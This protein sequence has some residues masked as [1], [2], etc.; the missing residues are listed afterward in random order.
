MTSDLSTELLQE[1][2]SHVTFQRLEDIRISYFESIDSTQTYMS[3]VAKSVR[4]GDVAI[5]RVQTAGKGREGRTWESDSGGLW[6]TVVLR[7]PSSKVLE[8]LVL[9]S[10]GAVVKTLEEFGL[11]ACYIKPPND[12][13]CDGKKI[14]GVLADAIQKSVGDST[15]VYLGVGI[16]VNNETFQNSVIRQIATSVSEQ[17]GRKVDLALF[18]VTILRNLDSEYAREIES[19]IPLD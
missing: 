1:L 9:V 10:S 2:L 16:D 5:S 17:L 7:P 15:V 14:A 18:A 4:E 13:Y 8:K 11:R 12:V 6:M 3:Q 19:C